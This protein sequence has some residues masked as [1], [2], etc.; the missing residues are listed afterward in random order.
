MKR[1]HFSPSVLSN[2]TLIDRDDSV[3]TMDVAPSPTTADPDTREFSVFFWVIAIFFLFRCILAWCLVLGAWCL[4][5][6][7]WC[8]VLVFLCFF[9]HLGI[10]HKKNVTKLFFFSCFQ[11]FYYCLF[12]AFCVLRFSVFR[13]ADERIS[14]TDKRCA[15]I[16]MNIQ[17]DYLEGGTLVG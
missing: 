6:G 15:L 10:Q 11:I 8:L 14:R 5:L 3:T 7:A 13:F 12:F 4:V 16:L 9:E 2:N 1:A 17:N